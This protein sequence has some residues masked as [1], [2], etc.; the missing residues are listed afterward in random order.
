MA[1]RI[2]WPW[3]EQAH[4][5]WE[6]GSWAR[7]E[8]SVLLELVPSAAGWVAARPSW[9]HAPRAREPANDLGSAS[10][11]GG[12]ER[13]RERESLSAPLFP[14][15]ISAWV[16]DGP[17]A[18]PFLFLSI[19]GILQRK[20][21][22]IYLFILG[23]GEWREKER[24]RNI[25]QLVA[26][27]T[28][29]NWEPNMQLRH[30]PRPGIE[31][32]TFCFA[33][34]C[35]AEGHTGQGLGAFSKERI[36]FPSFCGLWMGL[37]PL[38]RLTDLCGPAPPPTSPSSLVLEEGTQDCYSPWWCHAVVPWSVKSCSFLVKETGLC[39]PIY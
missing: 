29:P 13:E 8:S 33:E 32:V 21:P 7:R 3:R 15:I 2:T 23:R 10:L 1:A 35:P 12:G 19:V 18:F 17:V 36:N 34:Q 37:H 24:K 20:I 16:W 9:S 38:V 28:C 39:F 22:C 14:G 27:H 31:P 25:D 11:G 6:C 30:V 26:S 5:L 4:A